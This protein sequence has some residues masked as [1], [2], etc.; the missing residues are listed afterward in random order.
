MDTPSKVAAA[1]TRA[2]KLCHASDERAGPTPHA[3]Q[4][5]GDEPC[6]SGSCTLLFVQVLPSDGPLQLNDR[7]DPAPLLRLVSGGAKQ[8]MRPPNA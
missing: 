5:S 7:H 8:A 4:P 6:C 3:G 1:D 2:A